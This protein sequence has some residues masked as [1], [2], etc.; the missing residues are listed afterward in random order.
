MKTL[1]ILL[2]FLSI[3]AEAIITWDPMKI[4]S[5]GDMS[6]ATVTST[7]LDLTNSNQWAIQAVWTGSPVGTIKLQVSNDIIDSC[8]NATHWSDYTQTIQSVSGA[9][10]YLWNSWVANYHCLRLLYVKTSGTG[11]LNATYSRK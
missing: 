3:S 10:D 11:S 1:L 2:L 8:A 4:V 6:T 5:S 9:G 7:P